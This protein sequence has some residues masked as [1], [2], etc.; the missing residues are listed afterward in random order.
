VRI[1]GNVTLDGE[2]GRVESGTVLT[3]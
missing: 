1:V 3:S 2:R